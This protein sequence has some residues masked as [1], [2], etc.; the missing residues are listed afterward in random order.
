MTLL[1]VLSGLRSSNLKGLGATLTVE[2]Q[3][4]GDLVREMLAFT[5]NGS[6]TWR[7]RRGPAPRSQLRE[8]DCNRNRGRL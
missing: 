2:R 6:W 7:S 4:D 8:L 1:T 5:A 3:A